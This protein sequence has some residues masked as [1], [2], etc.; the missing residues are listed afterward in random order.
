[1]HKDIIKAIIIEDEENSRKNL[2]QLLQAHCPKVQIVA[3][4]ESIGQAVEVIT[5]HRHEID[6]AFLD[7]QLSDG[8]IFTLLDLLGNVDFDIIFISA[9]D[10]FLQKGYK[11]S[12]I[13]FLSKPI[14]IEALKLAVDRSAKHSE[15]KT[16]QRL[17]VLNQ[18]VQSQ[19][20]ID[21]ITISAMDSYHFLYL[22]DIIRLEGHDNYTVIFLESGERLTSSKTIKVFEDLLADK[23]F[24]RVHK[25]HIINVDHMKKFMKSDGG[26]I[27]T[28]DNKEIVVS[29]RRKPMLIDFLKKLNPDF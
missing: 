8:V 16:S 6:L 13:D 7:I 18:S 10:Q 2:I 22:K 29:R 14:D 15:N 5:K 3:E 26:A 21:R 12:A 20:N 19:G 25:S 24:F 17:E 9:Y 4:A 27:V 28:T 23:N 1:M 11:Y